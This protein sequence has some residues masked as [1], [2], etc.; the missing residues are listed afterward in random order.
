MR[1][2]RCIHA[3]ATGWL[4]SRFEAAAVALAVAKEYRMK[5]ATLKGGGRDG[6]L[7]VVSRDLKSA[8]SASAVVSTMMEA[9]ER[10]DSVAPGL[11]AIY[12]DLNAGTIGD[13][14]R[15]DPKAAAAPLP[16]A[17]Q[18]MDAS[19]FSAHG[20]LMKRALKL[21]R[22]PSAPFPL[23]L[24]AMASDLLGPLDDEPVVSEDELIDFEAELGVIT[25]AVPA[26]PSLEQAESAVKLITL[27]NDWS[28]R[29][30]VPPEI[31]SGFGFLRSKAP[32]A[33]A[34]VAVTPDELGHAWKD[35]RVHLP[36]CVDYNDKTWG[37]PSAAGMDYS[38]FELIVSAGTNRR[39]LPATIIGSG[40][41]SEGDPARVGCACIAEMR[42]FE[43]IEYGAPKTP[44]MRFGDSVRIE[45]FSAD[46]ASVF[47]A[48]HQRVIRTGK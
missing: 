25:G 12:A 47:G 27:L 38:F 21:D 33:F 28:L 32:T 41:I 26:R 4:A 10:W 8:V 24:Q 35:G 39:L 23:I 5:L 9:L 22:Q 29:A 19:T 1:S 17:N 30:L 15:F 7:V 20:N 46:G 36:V 14:F 6:R 42:G 45:M 43:I 18:W 40:A 3:G 44:F 2:R 31:N 48:I 16:R 37:N 34:P 11:I 13:T